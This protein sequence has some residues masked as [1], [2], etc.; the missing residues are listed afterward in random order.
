MNEEALRRDLQ[1]FRERYETL[2]SSR[3]ELV[4]KLNDLRDLTRRN[5]EISERIIRENSR[6]M[7]T[8]ESRHVRREDIEEA[9]THL[10]RLTMQLE[11]YMTF[12]ARIDDALRNVGPEVR[13]G[14]ERVEDSKGMIALSVIVSASVLVVSIWSTFHFFRHGK[15]SLRYDSN[16]FIFFSFSL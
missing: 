9:K 13:E 1:F 8:V 3:S 6:L 12:E 10:E 7:E 2:C 16:K 14:C 4:N 15:L 11:D 5:V